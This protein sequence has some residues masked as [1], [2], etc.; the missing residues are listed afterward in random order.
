MNKGLIFLAVI[1]VICVIGLL[2]A[3]QTPNQAVAQEP[4]PTVFRYTTPPHSTPTPVPSK[5]GQIVWNSGMRGTGRKV[6]ILSW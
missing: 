4:M 2:V 3:T 1:I 5:E 6:A